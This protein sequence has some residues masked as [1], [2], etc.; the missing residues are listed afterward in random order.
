MLSVLMFLALVAVVALS[1]AAGVGLGY[2]IIFG[3]LYLFDRSR[4]AAETSH[5]PALHS[6]ASGD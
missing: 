3:I 6:S 5:A 1:L 2:A 4:L